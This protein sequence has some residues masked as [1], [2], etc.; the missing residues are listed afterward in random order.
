MLI[1]TLDAPG[2]FDAA[3]KLRPGEP[4]FLLIGRDRLAPPRLLEWA[5]QNRL[6]ALRMG[7]F[8][9]LPELSETESNLELEKSTEAE[10]IAWSMIAYKEGRERKAE[11]ETRA[12]YTGHELPEDQLRRD[13]IQRARTKAAE[14][15][16]NAVAELSNLV[17]VLK[18][19]AR[20]D[21]ANGDF[22]M[23][24]DLMLSVA[25]DAI[26]HLRQLADTFVPPRPVLKR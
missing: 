9:G 16:H 25:E 14:C 17:D 1:N 23:D 7:E 11:P 2:E 15:V 18:A 8:E 24:L 13:R 21:D 22:G 26:P 4:Y 12:T 6:R 5:K 19:D 10:Q 20:P 3:T